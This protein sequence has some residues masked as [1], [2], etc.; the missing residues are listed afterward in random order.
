M[1]TQSAVKPNDFSVRKRDKGQAYIRL[2]KNIEELTTEE[3]DTLY[4]YDEVE[5]QIAD[6]RGLEDY[7]DANFGDLFDLGIEQ[8]NSP[9]EK[10]L[11]ERIAELEAKLKELS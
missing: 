3:G 4:S 10:T 7:V 8:A 11:E 1:K 5:V 2:R 6:R 9:K